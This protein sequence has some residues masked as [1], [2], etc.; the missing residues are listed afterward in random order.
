[1][2]KLTDIL[3]EMVERGEPMKLVK[4]ITISDQLNII[5]VEISL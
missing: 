1:M 4:D 5:W 2:I 3:D